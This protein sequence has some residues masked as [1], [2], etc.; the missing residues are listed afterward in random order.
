[1]EVP[2]GEDGDGEEDEA[3]GLVSAEGTKIGG[4]AG[5][6]G[7]WVEVGLSAVGH[8]ALDDFIAG[9]F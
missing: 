6:G 9:W 7:F 2:P 1:V 3:E 5:F 4:A 8:G